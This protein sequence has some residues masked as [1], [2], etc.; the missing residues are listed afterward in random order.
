MSGTYEVSKVIAATPW[1]AI[2][3]LLDAASE[4]MVRLDERMARDEALAEGSQGRAHFR[5]AC[6]ALWLEGELVHLEDLVLHVASMDIR[7][8]TT[9]VVRAAT[10]LRAR[11]AIRRHP[12]D[13]ALNPTGLAVLRGRKPKKTELK[14][15][16]G[17]EHDDIDALIERSD[18]TL[19]A[20][21][22]LALQ[23]AGLFF[24]DEEDEDV[25]LKEWL[26]VVRA[27]SELPPLLAAAIAWDAW[28]VIEPYR[29]QNYL[30]SLFVAS[31]LRM[32]G[33]TNWHLPTINLGIRSCEYRRKARD[34]YP[35]RL[36]GF[37]RAAKAGADLGLR[38]LAGLSLARERMVARLK[39]TRSSSRLPD[40]IQL[41]LSMPL[42]SVQIAAERMKVS[43]QAVEGMIKVLG[44]ALPREITGRARFRA[45]GIL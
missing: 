16:D 25:R 20:P 32:R 7:T 26:G 12:A 41:F 22:L 38:D 23:K 30:G 35:T 24:D 6:A 15:T 27:T 29:R 8:P 14:K 4:A 36:T 21:G 5:D 34:D 39:G 19:D 11:R 44:P 3:S 42:V 43:P 31:L 37:L 40:L 9:E 13:W 45:W 2:V 17:P 10:I 28:V 33:K 18:R 1:K